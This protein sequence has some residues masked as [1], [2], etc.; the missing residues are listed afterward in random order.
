M[1]AFNMREFASRG[2]ILIL[3]FDACICGYQPRAQAASETI[4][5]AR[6]EAAYHLVSL[7]KIT[8]G[9]EDQYQ[10]AVSPDHKSIVFTHKADLIA[11]LREQNLI[12]GEVADLLPLDSDSTEPS[13]NSAGAL[14]FVYYRFNARGDICSISQS[15]IN[16]RKSGEPVKEKEIHCLARDA[17]SASAERLNP[18]WLSDRE[19]GYL[20]RSSRGGTSRVVATDVMSGASRVLVSGRVWSPSMTPGG[21]YLVYNELKSDGE[22]R[23]LVL[24]DLTGL[25][26]KE[27]HFRVPGMTGFPQLNPGESFIYFS[28]Y[29]NDT[30]DD[31]IIDG[32]DNAVVLR[33]PVAD[34]LNAKDGAEVLPEQLTS[35]ETSCSFPKPTSDRLFVTCGFEGSLDLYEL[36]LSGVVPADWSIA[37][38]QN[39]MQSSRSYQ[40]RIL[41]LNAMEVRFKTPS[42]AIEPVLL[43]NHFLSDDTVAARYYLDR[44]ELGQ[45]GAEAHFSDL[46]RIYLQARERK[47]AQPSEEISREFSDEIAKFDRMASKTPGQ[48]RMQNLVRGLM[49][50]F[51]HRDGEGKSF[52]NR[53]SFKSAVIP[54]ENYS[55][56][57]LERHFYLELARSVYKM[58]RVQDR[59]ALSSAYHITLLAP[60]LNEQE[61]IYYAVQFL[62]A[63][64]LGEPSRLKRIELINAIKSGLPA[65]VALLFDG[66]IDT[67][68]IIEAKDDPTKLK[69]YR[70][71]DRLIIQSK[72]D[73]FLRRALYVRSI[74]SFNEAAEFNYLG[75]IAENWLRY[76]DADDTEL[77]YAREVVAEAAFDRAYQVFDQQ[78]Y[79]MAQG[80]FF[81]AVTYTDSLEAHGSYIK[82]M[83]AKNDRKAIENVYKNL[84]AHKFIGDNMK[85]VEALLILIDGEVHS[86]SDPTYVAH[87]D[88]AIQKLNQMTESR[89]SA[90]RYLL[91]GYSYLGK[92]LRESSGLDFPAATFAEAH[93]SL[94][95]AYDLGRDHDRIRASALV[96]L[97]VLH[98]RV[99]NFA[100]AS[101]FLMLRKNLGFVNLEEH[102]AFSWLYAEALYHS[103]QP[104]LAADELAELGNTAQTMPYAERAAFYSV[105]ALR[106]K[107]ANEIYKLVL[108][109]LNP[110]DDLN[111]ARV[112][113]SYGYSL[114]KNGDA[115]ESIRVLNESM[116]HASRLKTLKIGN[117]RIF[118]LN[119]LQLKLDALGFLSQEGDSQNRISALRAKIRLLDENAK[120]LEIPILTRAE[121][122]TQLA[123]LMTAENSSGAAALMKESLELIQSYGSGGDFLSGGVFHGLADFFVHA[124]L[125]PESYRDRS[126]K[127][128]TLLK[129]E[130]IKAYDAQ[131]S[132][133]PI[134]DYQKLELEMLYRNYQARL[135]GSSVAVGDLFSSHEAEVLKASAP[136]LWAKSQTLAKAL[137]H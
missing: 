12:S 15:S 118:E 41:L 43:T 104:A 105:S 22:N 42:A 137:S 126:E 120:S 62:Q 55:L 128:A 108:K 8:V 7:K 95:L 93:R 33:V 13:F 40:D 38:V 4:I 39:A 71:L 114:F 94:M 63:V 50:T 127:V 99:R 123:E 103:H 46:L 113:L 74:L 44:I 83:V 111:L 52:L 67:L 79:A 84:L 133:L 9:P 112:E 51:L 130:V 134:I 45:N 132:R 100:L 27:I 78:K 19:V 86:A 124:S 25:V 70:D 96:N 90:A 115:Q 89:E 65:N 106:F 6:N 135:H 21:H 49:Q 125:H 32:S 5:K 64:Q 36:P 98:I 92:L 88:A 122:R 1:N 121:A 58:E 136:A 37:V 47:K 23:G 131:Q 10:S 56:S 3:A 110:S 59:A 97:G 69:I 14:A 57:L 31:R 48:P 53:V 87:F 35:V 20:E 81:G 82:T 17:G 107:K 34:I 119:P 109:N 11:R 75:F 24:K 77:S 54:S 116:K 91:L 16:G 26:R 129:G 60:E 73:Y 117:D 72:G 28:H 102:K 66:E 61:L 76:T 101:H 85:F 2:L 30:N 29:L 18:F 80:Y 68:K